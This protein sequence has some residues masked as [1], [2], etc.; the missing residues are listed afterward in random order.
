MKTELGKQLGTYQADSIPLLAGLAIRLG[1]L[2]HRYARYYVST[3]EVY[4]EGVC[5]RARKAGGEDRCYG[6]QEIRKVWFERFPSASG[7]AQVES[8]RIDLIAPSLD[9]IFSLTE[10][11]CPAD[12][13]HLQLMQQL[14]DRWKRAT[15][16]HYHVV[17]AVIRRTAD[18]GMV[19]YLCMQKPDTRYAYTSRH[20]EF[21]GGKVETGET[22]P[23]AL[24]RELR[25][26]MDYEVSIDRHLTTVE[27]HYPDFSL[28]LSCWLCSA[29]TDQFTRK[30]HIDHR[31]LTPEE[32][33]ELE[34]C[35]ADAPVLELLKAL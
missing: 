2:K 5:L 18:D 13:P 15:W 34:W 22:E 23:E 19:R 21:P 14:H 29:T 30:E 6:W 25:E 26:E 17:A 1:W 27:H 24:A 4:E 28:S 8:F 12:S 20:W 16:K 10:H 31:W 3:L 35:E 33:T 9:V 11:D 7:K 32:M